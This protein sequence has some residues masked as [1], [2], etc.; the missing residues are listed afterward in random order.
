MDHDKLIERG[1]RWLKNVKNCTIVASELVTGA[2]EIPDVI[3]WKAWYSYL[4]EAKVSMADFRADQHKRFRKNA[5]IGVGIKRY[6]IVPSEMGDVI[7]FLPDGWGLLLC[8]SRGVHVVKESSEF[9]PNQQREIEIL[10]SI[11]RRISSNGKP[12]RGIGVRAYVEELSSKDPKSVL[13]VEQEG[14]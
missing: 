8:S 6:Y 12:I 5:D 4:I 13:Y 7:G 3:G 9:N 1:F 10:S 2:G 11:I 14:A